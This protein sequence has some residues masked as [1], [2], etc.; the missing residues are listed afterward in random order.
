[1][2]LQDAE[3]LEGAKGVGRRA[4]RKRGGKPEA[5]CWGTGRM[6]KMKG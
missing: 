1:V 3:R 6:W 5:V 4:R 2:L